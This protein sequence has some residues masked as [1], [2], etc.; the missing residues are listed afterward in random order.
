[1]YGFKFFYLCFDVWQRRANSRIFFLGTQVIGLLGY[2]LQG[3]AQEFS[4]VR[5][6]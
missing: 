3:T 5:E 1:M 6:V 2:F 4:A